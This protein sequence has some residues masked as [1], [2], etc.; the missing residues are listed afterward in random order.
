MG[1]NSVILILVTVAVL[2]AL[3][4]VAVNAQP[5]VSGFYGTV[6]VDGWNVADGTVVSA[7]IDG[8]KKAEAKTTTY[9][10]KSLYALDVA[11]ETA[12]EGKD[13]VFKIGDATAA[14]KGTYTAGRSVTLNLSYVTPTPLPFLGPAISISPTNGPWGSSVTVTGSN[15]AANET[16]ITVTYDATTVY[17]GIQASPLRAWSQTIVI[18]A[19]SPGFH[20][21][22]ARGSTTAPTST[23]FTTPSIIFS[24]NR[25][26]G[27]P[28]TSVTVTVT[29]FGV[30]EQ[31]IN[32]TYDGTSVAS[33]IS[34]IR[35]GFNSP[36]SP[37]AGTST[38]R[39]SGRPG[40]V[41]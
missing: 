9:G 6:T 2:L 12:L 15:F 20:T 26:S 29:G 5:Q 23:T 41:P 38:T 33:G 35:Q 11:G 3:F 19:S 4:P 18:P 27:A 13:V 37:A 16:G 25:Y 32:V 39:S 10:G 28:G 22:S 17:S 31:N 14:Q 1:K 21:I 30:N 7:W 36:R 24:L 8:V 40:I 34:A